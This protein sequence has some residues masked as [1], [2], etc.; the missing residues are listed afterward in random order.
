MTGE[1]AVATRG[2]TFSGVGVLKGPFQAETKLLSRTGTDSS[3]EI[4]ADSDTIGSRM[5]GSSQWAW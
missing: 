2:Q 1:Q 4:E 5:T 3:I